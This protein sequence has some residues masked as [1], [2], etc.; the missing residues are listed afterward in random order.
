MLEIREYFLNITITI[1]NTN[2]ATNLIE[3]VGKKNIHMKTGLMIILITQI[4]SIR[5]ITTPIL[6]LTINTKINTIDIVEKKQKVIIIQRNI[7]IKSNI[8]TLILNFKMKR[9]IT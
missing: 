4:L 2:S 8:K 5:H 9:D 7:M 1:Q 3:I 6:H